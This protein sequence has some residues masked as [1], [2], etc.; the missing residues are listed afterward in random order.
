MPGSGST[1]RSVR[2]PSAPRWP[3]ASSAR[4]WACS[5][6]AR[7][8]ATQRWSRARAPHSSTPG[9]PRPGPGCRSCST[10]STS[11]GRLVGDAAYLLEPDLKEARGGFRDVSM[12]RALAAT[13]L[14]DRP[15]E[16]VREPYERLL[17]VRDALHLSSGRSLDRLLLG[18]VD[19]VAGRLGYSETD[20]L[21]REVSMAARRI[22]HAVDVTA[23]AA[24]QAIPQRRVLGFVKRERRPE[25]TVAEHGLII[26]QGE[27]ALGP[28]HQGRR[29][30]GRAAGRGACRSAGPG[31]VTGHGREP[32]PACPSSA[33]PLAGRRTAGAPRHAVDRAATWCRCGRRWIWPAAS[34]AG[35]PAGTRSGP[36]RST[37]RSIST[38]STG[39][40]CRPS[41]RRSGI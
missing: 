7:S 8:P 9:E 4:E 32:R 35:F 22:G 21:R 24:R 33:D 1:I 18:E 11:G 5:T 26:H 20:E 41:S 16:G 31:A 28:A 34:P 14:T 40:R 17:D 13:W 27:V 2:R 12:L 25:Y 38:P 19:E 23:R 6:S 36:D 37:T 39:T 10:R 29:P 3:A 15:H 30:A